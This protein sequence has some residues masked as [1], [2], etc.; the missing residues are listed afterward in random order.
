MSTK[1]LTNSADF[2]LE[3]IELPSL[4]F[5][6]NV[7]DAAKDS[8]NGSGG[9]LRDI[10]FGGR[11]RKGS[12]SAQLGLLFRPQ[13]LVTLP[14]GLGCASSTKSTMQDQYMNTAND[15]SYLWEAQGPKS[16][17]ARSRP[18]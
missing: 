2:L 15:I 9:T 1:Y 17:L 16:D 6:G 18:V 5:S 11:T 3:N 14:P 7:G 12:W 13:A 10:V 4:A 8:L